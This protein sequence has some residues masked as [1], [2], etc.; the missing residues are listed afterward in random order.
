MHHALIRTHHI[1]SRKKIAA[2][3]AAAKKHGCFALLR[4]GGTPGIMY[5]QGEEEGVREWV[6][7]VHG[8]HYKDYHLVAAPAAIKPTPAKSG[9]QSTPS[10]S[11]KDADNTWSFEEIDTVKEFGKHME[12]K[13]V[14]EWW[15]KAMDFTS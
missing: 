2:L 13:G 10:S 6:G 5:V 12:E 1:T 8:L 4:S 7:V 14:L 15:R 3:K 9:P 11:A